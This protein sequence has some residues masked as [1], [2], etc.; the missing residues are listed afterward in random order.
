MNTILQR[1]VAGLRLDP[2]KKVLA[3]PVVA[4]ALLV[5]PF[6]FH[7]VVGEPDLERT[8]L[9]ILYGASSGLH[10]AAGYHYGLEVSFGYYAAIYQL[11]PQSVLL[12][13]SSLIEAINFIGYGSAVLAMGAL[14]LYV[15]RLFGVTAA[16]ITCT[17]FGFS[18]VFLD[19][20]TSG[21]PQVPGLAFTLIGAWL[22][23]Y[24]TDAALQTSQRIVAAVGSFVFLTAALTFRGDFV[25]AFPFVT[26][27]AADTELVSRRVWLRAAGTRVAL[28]LP[29]FAVFLVLQSFAFS[30]GPEGKAG[31]ISTF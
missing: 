17:L 16:L 9:A 25:L 27:V 10:E 19:L 20:G 13:S 29:A 5:F 23:T 12:H 7:G 22:L 3:M 14:A 18:P 6:V 11:L 2:G 15:A 4:S 30:S 21:H 31:F 26:L 8:V 24:V 1:R 28:L